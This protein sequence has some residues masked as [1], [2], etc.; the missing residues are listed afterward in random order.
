MTFARILGLRKRF[1][2]MILLAAAAT[3]AHG[4]GGDARLVDRIDRDSG[5]LGWGG[6]LLGMSVADVQ[7]VLGTPLLVP[8]DPRTYDEC[9]ARFGTTVR[10]RRATLG[11]GFDAPGPRGRLREITLIAPAAD[12]L[13]LVAAVKDRFPGVTYVAAPDDPELRERNDPQPV[14][15]TSFGDLVHVQPGIG[16]S[17]GQICSRSPGGE[18]A[19]R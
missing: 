12:R 8:E 14:Y 10:H 2:A 13:S 16:V 15:R 19:N 9:S 7:G 18:W 6:L 4:Q 1:A 17:F 11:L 5:I 3:S